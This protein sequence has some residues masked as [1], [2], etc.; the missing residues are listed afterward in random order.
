MHR[1]KRQRLGGDVK[2]WPMSRNTII[3]I[4]LTL[5]QCHVV[6]WLHCLW[7]YC[8]SFRQKHNFH[9]GSKK[10]IFPFTW[11]DSSQHYMPWTREIF[12]YYK[13]LEFSSF[14]I[15]TSFCQLEPRITETHSHSFMNTHFHFY[16]Y[17]TWVGGGVQSARAS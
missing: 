6:W 12:H 13:D 11:T 4:Q 15:N 9:N 8:F 10:T 5:T 7:Y 17:E 3:K 14:A 1:I 2:Q 16:F